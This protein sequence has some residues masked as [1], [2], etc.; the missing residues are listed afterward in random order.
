LTPKAL[1]TVFKDGKF[2]DGTAGT[3]YG[4]FADR[5]SS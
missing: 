2:Y 5:I 3:F 4:F 1:A